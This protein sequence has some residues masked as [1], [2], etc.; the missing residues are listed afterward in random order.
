[1]DVH[2]ELMDPAKKPE[3]PEGQP[4]IAGT[5]MFESTTLNP[6][7]VFLGEKGFGRWCE[8]REAVTLEIRNNNN[9]IDYSEEDIRSS[10]ASEIDRLKDYDDA[11]I[12]DDMPKVMH[13]HGPYR[14][15]MAAG[16]ALSLIEAEGVTIFRYD[17]SQGLDDELSILKSRSSFRADGC[18]LRYAM[19]RPSASSAPHSSTTSRAAFAS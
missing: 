1:M 9:K 14:V 15:T 17:P 11:C 10:V 6:G 12:S 18:I 5:M 2:P 16:A 7:A 13:R 4:Y 3:N 8:T 19:A